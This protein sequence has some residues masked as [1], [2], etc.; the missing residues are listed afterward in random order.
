MDQ[1]AHQRRKP[2]GTESRHTPLTSGPREQPTGQ[3]ERS[4]GP[5]GGRPTYLVGRP[6][7]GPH[8]L[9]SSMSHSLNGSLSRFKWFPTELL[10]EE[11]VAPLYI[12]EGR[13]S[14]SSIQSHPNHPSNPNPRRDVVS[15]SCRGLRTRGVQVRVVV[16][17]LRVFMESLVCLLPSLYVIL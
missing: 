2:T 4:V 17:G 14:I 3:R 5:L 13:G 8:R 1:M 7:H 9:Q 6:A 11:R 15:F 10:A 12:Y 16:Q